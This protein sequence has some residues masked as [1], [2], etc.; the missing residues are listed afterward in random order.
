M[1]DLRRLGW[2]DGQG[3]VRL[4]LAKGGIKAAL[5]GRVESVLV[6]YKGDRIVIRSAEDD[7]YQP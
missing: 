5:G 1:P 4:G 3:S 7:R 2:Y 6:Y